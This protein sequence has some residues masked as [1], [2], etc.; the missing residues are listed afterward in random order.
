MAN[1]W[2]EELKMKASM[3][4]KFFSINFIAS[5]LLIG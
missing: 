4:P 2:V 5:E 1:Q 3:F